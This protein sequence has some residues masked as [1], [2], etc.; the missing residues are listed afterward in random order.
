MV[1]TR[2]KTIKKRVNPNNKTVDKDQGEN[3]KENVL[4][5]EDDKTN[6]NQD[7]GHQTNYPVNTSIFDSNEQLRDCIKNNDIKK[8]END[9]WLKNWIATKDRWQTIDPKYI[10]DGIVPREDVTF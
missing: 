1:N 8:K 9:E 2:M 5:T 10:E 7:I 6:A 3:T 4:T